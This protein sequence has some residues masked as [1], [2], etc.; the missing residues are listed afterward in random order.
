MPQAS[1]LIVED[2]PKLA[3]LLKDYLQQEGYQCD[4]IGDGQQALERIR[5]EA[6]DLILL[7]LMLPG[8]DGLS[9]CRE[10]RRFTDAPIIM[11]TARVEEID[12][13]LGLELGAD[14]YVCKPFSPREVVAR[15]KAILR[16]VRGAPVE[17]RALMLDP[18][19]YRAVLR[20]KPL[21]LTAIEFQLLKIL[22]DEPGRI[23]SRSQLMDGIYQDHRI[24]SDR[25]V[26][27]HIKKLRKK[28]TELFPDQDY[29]HS[30]YGLGYKYEG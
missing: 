7:D 17:E 29:I 22:A 15:V 20:G 2:E 6:P 5:A 21:E 23:F 14:D 8:L 28:M 3:S 24:V 9:V 18:S 11:V 19:R 10:A 25:T 1:I 26:D 30:V 16:R 4:I 13:L 27:S 12:R